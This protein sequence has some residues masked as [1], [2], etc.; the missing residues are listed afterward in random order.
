MEPSVIDLFEKDNILHFTINNINVSFINA[1]R[2]VILSDIPTIVIRTTPYEKNDVAIEVNTSIFHNEILKH[3]LSCIPIFHINKLLLNELLYIPSD[4]LL[5]ELADYVVEVNVVN[6]TE[7]V[8]Y[9]TT[10]DF[11]I[12]Y[13]KTNKYLDESVVS[14]VFPKNEITQ[15]FIEFCKLK[16]KYSENIVGEQLTLTAK[17]SVGSASENGSFNIVSLCSYSCTLDNF[18]IDKAKQEKLDELQ[19]K[20]TD[21]KEI[22]YLITDW[23]LLDAKR[24][25][26]P[27][28][29]DFRIK[30]LGVF[31]NYEIII[32]AIK[33]IIYRLLEIKNI[34][35]TQNDLIINSI[36]TVENCYDIILKTEDYTIGKVLEYSL[37]ELYYNTTKTLTFCGFKKPHPHID[38]SII[39]IAFNSPVEK[40]LI[41][42]YITSAADYAIEY[43]KKLLPNFGELNP[44][45]LETLNKAIP[46]I[47]INSTPQT[48]GQFLGQAPMSQASMS[49]ASMSQAPSQ[50]PMSQASMSQAS[51][52]QASMSQAPSQAPMS[53]AE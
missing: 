39:R 36:N 20:Y 46:L 14:K 35:T 18:A 48:T 49:Q 31:T 51:M 9:V 26:I 11:K 47:K 41:I 37:Y 13:L 28:S 34:Y 32:K 12:K 44:D 42:E 45:E 52:S 3:R 21:D 17:L 27:D 10:G 23:L 5:E 53:Q 7:Q 40:T 38:E 30:T 50:A 33:I 24:I 43:F 2:R 1:L 22:E 6:N 29:F 25:V 15:H 4:K 16:P 19:S 8:I